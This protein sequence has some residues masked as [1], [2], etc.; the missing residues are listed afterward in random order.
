MIN[1]KDADQCKELQMIVENGPILTQPPA[2]IVYDRLIKQLHDLN[3]ELS[4]RSL[5]S[6]RWKHGLIEVQNRQLRV[7]RLNVLQ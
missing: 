4:N 7:Q 5:E 2:T 3:V 6:V 1:D